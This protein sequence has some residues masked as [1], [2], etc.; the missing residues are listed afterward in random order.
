MTKKNLFYPAFVRR[1]LTAFLSLVTA[2]LV[3]PGFLAPVSAAEV[4]GSRLLI[5]VQGED[6]YRVPELSIYYL[7]PE[8]PTGEEPKFLGRTDA[9]GE[10]VF[11]ELEA[12]EFQFFYSVPNVK[13]KVRVPYSIK[14]INGRPTLTIS[15]PR[16]IGDK[17]AE[18]V[19][20]SFLQLDIVGFQVVD[21]QG[22]SLPNTKLFFRKCP[23]VNCNNSS[24]DGHVEVFTTI[25]DREGNSAR[26][27]MLTGSYHI[28]ATVYDEYH[29]EQFSEETLITIAPEDEK[30]SRTIPLSGIKPVETSQPTSSVLTLYFENE[31]GRPQA[32]IRVG[33]REPGDETDY[34]LGCADSQGK[35]SISNLKK[36]EYT[37]FYYLDPYNNQNSN[38][39]DFEYEVEDTMASDAVTVILPISE[40]DGGVYKTPL[41]KWVIA[42]SKEVEIDAD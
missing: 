13:S 3:I 1:F 7:P 4:K 11:T 36:G 14:D 28:K 9:R 23:T 40:G 34:W 19:A 35:I 39:T 24:E 15:D 12:G 16:L 18:T 42:S 25:T 37:F 26:T 30:Q 22:N 21:A 17:D 27:N 38:R 20:E 29:R 10:L 31:K 6:G 8:T 2:V 32:D 33:Y 5:Q 41:Q